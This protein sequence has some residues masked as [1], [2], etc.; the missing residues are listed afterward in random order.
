MD[1]GQVLRHGPAAH[2]S[3]VRN[4]LQAVVLLHAAPFTAAGALEPL[5]KDA[6]R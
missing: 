1:L 4:L 3:A 5:K 6:I 2:A